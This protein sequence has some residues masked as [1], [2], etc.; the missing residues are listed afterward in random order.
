MTTP[1]YAQRIID[2][3]VVLYDFTEATGDIIH[4]T[5]GDL[6]LYVNN[7]DNTHWIAGGGIA[8]Y[9]TTRIESLGDAN[10]L[11][12]DCIA[13]NELTIE[14]W[15]MPLTSTASGP[16]RIMSL[17]VDGVL[18]GGNFMVGQVDNGIEVRCR[19]TE[20]DKYGKPAL[21]A[22]DIFDLT[23]PQQ[24]VYTKNLDG[25]TMLYHNATHIADAYIG[26]DFTNWIG[27]SL[28][29]ANESIDERPWL[30]TLYLIAVYAKALEPVEILTNYNAGYAYVTPDY[31]PEIDARV[32]WFA[33][34]DG[35]AVVSYI[36]QYSLNGTDWVPYATTTNTSIDM[37]LT[38]FDQHRVMVAGRDSLDRQG[39]Y[40]DSSDILLPANNRPHPAT[41]P[42][43]D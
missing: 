16:G 25:Y 19:T 4:D 15:V 28:T 32:E 33:P 11:I 17:S 12:N 38:F 6:D 18:T 7:I 9:A 20:S 26:G 43:R 31:N 13:S 39:P 3:L 24:I 34:I 1:I 30:G 40:S 10:N 37:K 29:L 8:I 42:L 2:Q 27:A 22:S 36:V 14:I 41:K 23:E 21:T 5:N 35:A